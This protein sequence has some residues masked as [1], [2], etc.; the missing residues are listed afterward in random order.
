MNKKEE[1]EAE[2]EK[3]LKVQNLG[4][5]YGSFETAYEL[6]AYLE[7]RTIPEFDKPIHITGVQKTA[8]RKL[9]LSRR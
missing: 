8:L 3:I 1:F 5:D 9:F 6:I 4:I 7:G 2:V